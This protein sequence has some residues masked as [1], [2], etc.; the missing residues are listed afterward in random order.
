VDQAIVGDRV[1]A[2]GSLAA[3]AAAA[4][5]VA[6]I[7]SAW[8]GREL[9]SLVGWGRQADASRGPHRRLGRRFDTETSREALRAAGWSLGPE[10]FG[11][12]RLA[13]AVLG[14]VLALLLPSGGLLLAPVCALVGAR[15]PLIAARRASHRRRTRIDTEVPQLLD[16]LAATSSAGLSTPL[17][18]RRAADALRG[19][20][21]GEIRVAL[22]AVDLGAR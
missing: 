15:L 17:A 6:A 9:A 19:P 10:R 5:G 12:L 18:L 16:L 22:D 11:E 20:L 2:L 13:G 8:G 1:I 7:R 21:G 3:A 14:V 4:S